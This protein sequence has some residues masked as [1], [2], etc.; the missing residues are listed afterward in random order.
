MAVNFAR[1]PELLDREQNSLITQDTL[2]GFWHE[3]VE[4]D[5][6]RPSTTAVLRGSPWSCLLAPR[7]NGVAKDA[8]DE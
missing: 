5:T 7:E 6:F 3:P 1:L 4:I 2:A 8:S